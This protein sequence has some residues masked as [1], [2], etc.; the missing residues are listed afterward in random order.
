MTDII[1][2]TAPPTPPAPPSPPSP[3]QFN[4][5]PWIE[6]LRLIAAHYRMPRSFRA[7]DAAMN[8]A[9]AAQQDSDTRIRQLAAGAGF[10]VQLVAGNS[11][12]F[13]PER[14][15]MIVEFTGGDIGVVTA[16]NA[17][18][19][20]NVAIIGE[21]GLENKFTITALKSSVVRGIIPRP[22]R[23]VRDARVDVYIRRHEPHWL[24]RIIFADLGSYS[25]VLLASFVA[26]I[27][28]MAGILFSMQV[29]DRVIPAAS[30]P[31]LYVLFTGVMI[32]I[33]FD[34]LFR[35]FRMRIID[36][37]GKRADLRMSDQVFGHAL[38]VK[39]SHRPM[40]TG[41]FIA[42][43]RE[44]EQVRDLLT[45]TTVAAVADIPFFLLFLAIFWFI[46]GTLALV[47]LTALLLLIIPGLLAQ[48]RLRAYASEAMREGSLRNAMLVE[49][50][51]GFEDIKMLQAEP[52]YQSLWNQYNAATSDAQIKLRDLTNSLTT[53]T[54]NV[55]N[56]VYASVIFVGAP[57][58]M[59]GT[60][61]TG[62]LVGASILGSRMIA[63][64]AQISQVLNRLQH[65]KIAINSLDQIMEMPVDDPDDEHRIALPV[66][67]GRLEMNAATFRYGDDN[68]PPALTVN[69][70]RIAPGERIAILGRN[71]AGKS[72][73]L[74]GCSGLLQP[75]S[76]DVLLDGMA[77]HQL[78]PADVRR[79]IGLISQTSRLFHGTIHDNLTLGAPHATSDQ[80][81]AALDI[82]GAA[83]F[84]RTS[85]SGLD[86]MIMEGGIGLSGGQVQALL[87]ARTLIRDPSIL[88]LDE[89]TAWMD[90]VSER[91]FLSKFQQWSRNRT[92]LIATH[93]MRALDLVDRV[94][95]I[96]GG[97]ITLDEPKDSALQKI[98]RGGAA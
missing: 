74:Q 17:V 11:L 45:S 78:D 43:L 23:K 62:V 93:R 40:S 42:Q 15:P 75:V 57:L 80:I 38:R 7:T 28:A 32:A 59:E 91:N 87:L 39:N 90:D 86:Y 67:Q 48:S 16:M 14:L 94:I 6:A 44:L 36:I 88:L 55:Q 19:D 64:I 65:A 2:T 61:T 50:I 46:G 12:R 77:L 27:L 98:Q 47:P 82:A 33:L 20:A 76:G 60:I 92:L 81:M 30:L 54:Q 41:S 79:H 69:N 71:G 58:V 18:G 84:I 70:L 52:R 29:Y 9:D 66:T 53:W 37:L 83:E 3:P 72:T 73:L 35:R 97:M 21:A 1:V 5:A 51:Q 95:V 89:P 56:A 13:S 31:T 22:A 96:H 10:A 25:H 4:P 85:R 24:R 68:N 34:F 8:G 49:S 63:P 26:N